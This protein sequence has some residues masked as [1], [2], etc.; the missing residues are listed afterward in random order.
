VTDVVE[1]RSV[2]ERLRPLGLVLT[3]SVRA[4]PVR[5]LGS[6]A[7]TLCSELWGLVFAIA[8]RAITDRAVAR[9]VM[10]TTRAGVALGLGTIV[11]VGLAWTGIKL[12][13][14]LEDKVLLAFDVRI[15][16]ALGRA[17]TV[18][19]HE[20]PD[21]LDEV[22]LLRASRGMLSQATSSTVYTAGIV[23]HLVSTGLLLGQISPW[24]LLLP[25][26]A[27]PS[28][29]A[30]QREQQLVIDHQ[31]RTAE[32]ARAAD[33]L[34]TVATSGAAAGELRLF[35]VG[36]ELRRRFDA[37]WAD[38]V[39]DRDRTH[40]RRL[41][42]G[43][44]GYASFGLGFTLALALVAGRAA[45]G[46]ATIG[47]LVLALTLA[48]EVNARVTASVGLVTWMQQC[49]KTVRRYLRILDHAV[50]TIPAAATIQ[51]DVPDRLE[52]GIRL[53]AV[54]F[55]YPGTER[56]V[57]EDVDLHIPAGTTVAIVGDNGAG[58]STLVKLLCRFYEPT[59]GRVL[60]DGM[61]LSSI[62]PEQ[63]R[64]R[65][66]AG[67]QDFAK[68]ELLARETVGVGSLPDIH[69]EPAIVAAL[70]RASATDVLDALPAHL[71]SQLGRT[72]EGGVELSGGQWQKLALGRAMMRQAPLVL[73]LDEPT[74][75]LD[76]Q[77]E[78]ALFERYA[79][80]A[81]ATAMAAGGITILVSH[82]F[83]TVRMADLIVVVGDHGVLEV[84]DHAT[85]VAAGGTYADLYDLQARAYR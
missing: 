47:D 21:L 50:G 81:R 48:A 54:S 8:F 44:L 23:V 52:D 41:L 53:E 14:T 9:D 43:T 69:A 76:P 24:L 35:G 16:E 61:P 29:W 2:R 45:D 36:P 11:M 27:L 26:S 73:V 59:S 57:L 51:A 31:E 71:G 33:H 80:A 74:A 46:Q 3:T 63:W 55:R 7:A 75:A 62:D 79:G 30:A 60:V 65:L 66:S 20:R 42:L 10:G 40:R 4:D 64:E 25:I 84:G 15:S 77:T 56:M 6:C 18:E 19:H 68:L 38:M 49:L 1:K 37:T 82:R 34:F 39:A 22:E 5:A 13:F 78:H 72:F 28:L 12:R 32:P 85:L 17:V 70:D 67:F 58:K 83:S